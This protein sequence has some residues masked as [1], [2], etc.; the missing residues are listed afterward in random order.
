[1][2]YPQLDRSRLAIQPLAA[3]QNKLRIGTLAV[4][5]DTPPK[6]LVPE[7][8]ALVRETAERIRAARRAGSPVMLSFGAHTIKNGLGPVLIRLLEDGWVQHLATNGAGIIHDWEFAFQGQS[9]EDVRAGVARGEFGMWQETGFNLNLALLLGAYD[10]LG[11]GEA[12]GRL[13][14][15]ERHEIPERA[16]LLGDLARAAGETGCGHDGAIPLFDRAAAAADLLAAMESGRLRSGVVPVPHPHK[17]C[18]V[19]AAAYRLGMPFTGH[20]MIGHDIIYEHPLNSGAAIGRSAQR[21]FLA[22]AANVARLEGGV[23]LSVGSAVMSPMIFEKSLA[24]ARN[25]ARQAGQ[26]LENFFVLVVDLAPSRWDW[27]K[28]EPPADSSEYYLRYCKTFSRMGGTMRY[29]A[30][31]NRDFLPALLRELR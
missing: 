7:A 12:V 2:P 15:T 20:P 21:D 29:L 9:S 4:T 1:M 26:R 10:G 19:Q 11:Y 16:R 25:L 14:H 30:A 17:A 8:A 31:D 3:R 23:Y 24:M 18:S 5:P 6:S 13:I 28:G 27:S 22:F